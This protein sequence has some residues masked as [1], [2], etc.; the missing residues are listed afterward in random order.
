MEKRLSTTISESNVSPRCEYT[1]ANADAQVDADADVD[2]DV[3][4][5][6]DVD[7]DVIGDVENQEEH[8]V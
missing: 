1:N 8:N 5:D 2:V 3:D 7:V 6:A 4:V